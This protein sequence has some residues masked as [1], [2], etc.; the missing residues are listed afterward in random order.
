VI[1]NKLC[2]NDRFT[3]TRHYLPKTKHFN[4]FILLIV[5]HCKDNIEE[6]QR[7]LTIFCVSIIAHV[8]FSH[9]IVCPRLVGSNY[10]LGIFK[11]TMDINC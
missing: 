1:F 6:L 2:D 9:F 5:H 8:S 11:L 3:P 7:F 10:S 4:P